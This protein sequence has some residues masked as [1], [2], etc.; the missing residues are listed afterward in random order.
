MSRD[1]I[2]SHKRRGKLY[3]G[4]DKGE[5]LRNRVKRGAQ[6]GERVIKEGRERGEE[7][8]CSVRKIRKERTGEMGKRKCGGT[9]KG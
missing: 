9:S 6:G 7:R 5:L 4:K 3:K 1:E 2:N 8:E